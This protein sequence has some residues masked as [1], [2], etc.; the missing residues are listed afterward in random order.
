MPEQIASLADILYP[1]TPEEFFRDYH[2]KKPVHIPGT[3][4]KLASVM[5]WPTLSSLL[6][7]SGL[8]SG[9]S[10]QLVL[11]TRDRA[12]SMTRRKADIQKINLHRT[13]DVYLN[14]ITNGQIQQYGSTTSAGQLRTLV[15][16]WSPSS[17]KTK[18]VSC[19]EARPRRQKWPSCAI[20]AGHSARSTCGTVASK[21]S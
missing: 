10:L 17:A 18:T 2:G 3:P 12:R 13:G 7:Q 4:D 21:T 11:D 16:T 5:D 1:L 20:T 15:N 6:G 14:T 19:S 9:K 8:W